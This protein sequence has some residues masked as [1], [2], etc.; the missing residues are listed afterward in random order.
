MNN[1]EKVKEIIKESFP[2]KKVYAIGAYS[3]RFKF[4]GSL[5]KEDE[6]DFDNSLLIVLLFDLGF[7]LFVTYAVKVI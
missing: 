2:E 7:N 4:V 1:L 6:I 3:S 5:D